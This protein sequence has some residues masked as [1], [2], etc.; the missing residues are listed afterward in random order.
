MRRLLTLSA[1]LL[2]FSAV[3]AA[4]IWLW[5]YSYASHPSAGSG[6]VLIQIP[7]G[8]GVKQIGE[9]LEEKQV[10]QND[11]RFL[12][13]ARLSGSANHLQAGEFELHYGWT[14]LEILRYL[15]QGKV[16]YHSLTIPE[17]VTVKEVVSLFSGQ[18]WG[19]RERML[20]LVREKAFCRSLG[21]E[22]DSLEGYLFPDT[23]FLVRGET[24]E[25]RILAMMV[26]R[27]HRVWE[28]LSIPE[29][30]PF[31]RHQTV[32][33]ASI[34]EKETASAQER[35]HIAGVFINR[36]EKGMR[37]QSDPTV[38]Y[39][40]ENFSGD[41]TRPDLKKNTPYNTYVIR[42]LPVGP[43]C[44]P[45]KE[46]LSAVLDPVRSDALYF[47]SKNDGTHQFS[48]TLKEHNKAVWKYQKNRKGAK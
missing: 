34:V 10:L 21:I 13:L 15:E 33:L 47:V 7:R 39:G 32:T 45:G 26:D 9:L 48:P 17:G 19:D 3:C 43:I 36:L 5:M 20:S 2:A 4:G 6:T 31:D 37:L 1:L 41:L 30:Y 40:L 27:F 8:A 28:G 18:G 22:Q 29:E 11:I 25:R 35:P 23:Y 38:I 12:L 44:N 16:Y 46:A 24:D 14:P 42:G